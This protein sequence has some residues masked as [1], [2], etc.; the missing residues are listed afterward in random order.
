MARASKAKQPESRLSVAGSS[1]IARGRIVRFRRAG[2]DSLV[3]VVHLRS[4]G[5][6]LQ[7]GNDRHDGVSNGIGRVRCADRRFAVQFL[8]PARLP[9]HGHGL[10]PR[11]DAVSRTK[12]P[13][14]ADPAGLRPA[15][16]RVSGDAR[17]AVARC[18][19]CIFRPAG[20]NETAGG[21]IGQVVGELARR[22]HEAAGREH[23]VV[24]PLDCVDL[25]VSRYF[26]DSTSWTESATGPCRHTRKPLQDRRAA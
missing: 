23:A 8:R 7:P 1:G 21:I 6:G 12:D 13:D 5:P 9:V 14:R 10:L 16:R 17:H 24:L 4:G 2:A 26:L 15:F 18:Q 19:R 11:L 25:V 22:R 20:F 3:C